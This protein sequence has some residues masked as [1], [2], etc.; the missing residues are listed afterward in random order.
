MLLDRVSDALTRL[1]PQGAG[2]VVAVSG[3]PDS[4]ALLL[5]LHQLHDGP[6]VLAHINHQL[7]GA[8]SDADESFVRELHARLVSGASLA[9][10]EIPPPHLCCARVDMAAIAANRGDNLESAAREERYRWLTEV[11]REHGLGLVATGHTADDQ[12]ETVL[13]R[14]LRG[15]GLQGMR[16][17]AERRPLDERVQ[18]IRPLLAVSRAEVLAFLKAQGVTARQDSSNADLGF[19]RNRIR[20]ELLPYLEKH[21]NPAVRDVMIR[22]AHEASEAYDAEHREVMALLEQAERSRVAGV[23]MLDRETLRGST[24]RRVRLLFRHVWQREHWPTGR[25]THEHWQR[26]EELVFDELTATELPEGPQAR[27]W[28]HL[29]EVGPRR[30]PACLSE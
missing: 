21:F 23:V 20:H 12:A 2:M 5:A 11:A 3:G 30:S 8:E 19:T 22:L 28:K 26:L 17:I 6:L 1:A 25:M 16:G 13:H 24:R 27:R 18:L 4:V 15:A 29:I 9:R 14:L 7:R 10:R